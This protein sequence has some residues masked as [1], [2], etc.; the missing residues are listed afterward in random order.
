MYTEPL[1]HHLSAAQLN[2]LHDQARREAR[3]LRDAAFDELW[4]RVKAGLRA[5]LSAARRTAAKLA[6]R[7]PTRQRGGGFC[8]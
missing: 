3:V 1:G 6:R 8:A 4:N 2:L 7:P 5:G